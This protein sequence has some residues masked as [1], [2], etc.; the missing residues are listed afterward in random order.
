M[1]KTM[2]NDSYIEDFQRIILE[3]HLCSSQ[4]LGCAPCNDSF[5]EVPWDGCVEVF[6]LHGHRRAKRCF[7][8]LRPRSAVDSSVRFFAVLESTFVR[9]PQ[10]ALRYARLSE[11]AELVQEFSSLRPSVGSENFHLVTPSL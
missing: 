4:H 11:G 2:S 6:A 1:A 5:G 7:C 9:T 10:D 8:W 3:L